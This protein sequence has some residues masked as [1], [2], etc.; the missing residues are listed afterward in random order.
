MEPGLENIADTYLLN[1]MLHNNGLAMCSRG[2]IKCPGLA[3]DE[4]VLQMV[5]PSTRL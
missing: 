4:S 1:S 3:L 2:H 5:S